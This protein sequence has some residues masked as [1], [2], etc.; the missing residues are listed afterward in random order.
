VVLRLP[1][2]H[3]YVSLARLTA[4]GLAARLGFSVDDIED[5]RIAVDELC[6]ILLG[7][8]GRAGNITLTFS[9]EGARLLVNGEL[10]RPGDTPL[11]NP[12]SAQILSAVC[13]SHEIRQADGMLSFEVAHRSRS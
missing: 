3:A 9:V 2:Q 4:A 8:K 5:V 12:L 6:F 11:V 10:D 7:D 13:E 1:A